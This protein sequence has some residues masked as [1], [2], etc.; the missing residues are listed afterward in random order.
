MCAWI[1]EANPDR[2][3][4]VLSCFSSTFPSCNW[5]NIMHERTKIKIEDMFSQGM[6]YIDHMFFYWYSQKVC[7]ISTKTSKE[8]NIDIFIYNLINITMSNKI[9]CQLHQVESGLWVKITYGVMD[10]PWSTIQQVRWG[11]CILNTKQ[12]IYIHTYIQLYFFPNNSCILNMRLENKG[13]TYTTSW[14][15]N[16]PDPQNFVVAWVIYLMCSIG[17]SNN[18]CFVCYFE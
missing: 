4:S 11:L 6:H 13:T 14:V 8:T 15:L 18:M 2:S 7:I 16:V 12:I 17:E 9:F 1:C 3:F 10:Q 5:P